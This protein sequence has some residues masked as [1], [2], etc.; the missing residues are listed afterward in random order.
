MAKK[1]TT[2]GSAKEE[3]HAV[4][5]Y[6][7]KVNRPYS[8]TDVFNN[9]HSKYSKTHIIKAL[10]K[11]VE[12][13][14]VMSKT[15]G[16]SV[17]Y[18]IKQDVVESDETGQTLDSLEVEINKVSDEL[19]A[20]KNENKKLE[21]E[22]SK[23]KSDLTT[24]EVTE[25]IQKYKQ[26]NDELEQRLNHLKSGVVLIPPEKRKRADEEF[27]RNRDQWKKRRTMFQTIFKTVTEHM[28]GKP[29]ELKEELGI[30]E[31]SI[32]YDKDP[33]AS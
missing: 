28:P 18:S 33:L 7:K 27:T 11:L 25:L 17:V 29:D 10:D 6:M 32:P 21:G 13:G 24:K 3:E 2:G 14:K 26:E 20:V 1:K 5:E 22:L 30:E 4:L 16:K 12:E 23:L 19:N 31:D 15:Y 8:A 9:L